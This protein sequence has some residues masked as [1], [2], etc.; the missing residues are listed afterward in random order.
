MLGVF[1]SQAVVCSWY[2]LRV[3]A[4]WISLLSSSR[5]VVR[6][7]HGH[8]FYAPFSSH[9]F[10]RGVQDIL[11]FFGRRLYASVFI[12]FLVYCGHVLRQSRWSVGRFFPRFLRVVDLGSWGRFCATLSR[13]GEVRIVSASVAALFVRNALCDCGTCSAFVWW[14]L[15]YFPSFST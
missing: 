13:Q 7:Q 11:D 10:C 8:Y 2:C 1:A 3:D 14:L 15:E 4:A 9:L 5:V 12:A 6:C